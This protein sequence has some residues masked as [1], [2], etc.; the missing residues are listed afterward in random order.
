MEAIV[1]L[2]SGVVSLIAG[3]IAIY[4]AVHMIAAYAEGAYKGTKWGIEKYKELTTPPPMKANLDGT[5]TRAFVR[6]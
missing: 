3:A 2:V 6:G 5:W 1:Y 4:L